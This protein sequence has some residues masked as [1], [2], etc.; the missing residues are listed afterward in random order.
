MSTQLQDT[1]LP[2]LS[3]TQRYLAFVAISISMFVTSYIGNALSTASPHILA[4]I[5][6]TDG[7]ALTFT[8]GNLA[9]AI[10]ILLCGKFN[11]IWGRKRCLVIGYTFFGVS[12]ALCANAT[13]MVSMIIFRAIQGVG[14][15]FIMGVGAVVM[16]DLFSG[17]SKALGHSILVISRGT[18]NATSPFIAGLVVDNM[19]WQWLFYSLLVVVMIGMAI[20]VFGVPNYTVGVQ[21]R[22]YDFAGLATAILGISCIALML[23]LVNTFFPWGSP[24]IIM[25]GLAGAAL[26]VAFVMV[27]RNVP[28]EIAVMPIKL[29]KQRVF[30]SAT[31]GQVAMTINSVVL[32]VYVPVWIQTIMGQSA[33]SSGMLMTINYGI[34][35]VLSFVISRKVHKSGFYRRYALGTCVAEAVCH[36]MLAIFMQPTMPYIVLAAIVVGYGCSAAIESFIF[37][38]TVQQSLTPRQMSVGTNA[39]SF[40]LSFAG[41][42]GVAIGGTIM[43]SF[44]ENIMLGLQWVFRFAAGITVLGT[45][46]VAVYM[47]REKE[48]AA[49]RED[50]L[51]KEDAYNTEETSEES[52][53]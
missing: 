1:G 2:T 11:D 33:T 43:T 19:P 49:L 12:L 13:S 36:L 48:I 41:M 3:K 53:G 27:E 6:A 37:I 45:I 30:L 16:G 34:T 23:S 50:A 9:N 52:I 42:L 4:Q 25:L 10:T 46:I 24:V 40:V 38:F 39:M 44:G 22:K 21:K 26:M 20:T 51:R 32:M 28:E 7:Y 29:V 8:A 31:A 5:G 47:P 17:A 35:T 18:A 14:T 15:G